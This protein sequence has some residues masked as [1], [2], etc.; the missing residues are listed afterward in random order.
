MQSKT[1]SDPG[2]PSNHSDNQGVGLWSKHKMAVIEAPTNGMA[3][4]ALDFLCRKDSTSLE[5]RPVAK[6]KILVLALV[7][8][9]D[10]TTIPSLTSILTD[11]R[12]TE[13][14]SP[15]KI[16]LESVYSLQKTTKVENLV[17][18]ESESIGELLKVVNQASTQGHIII[19][20]KF[21]AQGKAVALLTGAPAQTKDSQKIETHVDV[22][23]TKIEKPSEKFLQF[24]NL[25]HF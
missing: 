15:T 8:A 13:I 10:T 19:E 1:P 23:K 25:S 24:F 6:D 2:T 9:E 11:C 22:I 17:I 20:I 5:L 12:V 3:Y 18:L 16:F 14:L 21:F 7:N 4:L